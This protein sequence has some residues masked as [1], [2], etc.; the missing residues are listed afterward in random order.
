MGPLEA[1]EDAGRSLGGC[2]EAPGSCKALMQTAEKSEKMGWPLQAL[3]GAR[4][5]E[6]RRSQGGPGGQGALNPKS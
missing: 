4:V 6:S 1:W 3:G 2:W 5:Q